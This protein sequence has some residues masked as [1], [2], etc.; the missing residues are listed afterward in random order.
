MWILLGV[1]LAAPRPPD[2]ADARLSWSLR[3]ALAADA[4]GRLDAWRYR[5]EEPVGKAGV[6]VVVHPGPE[7]DPD[8]LR[9]DLEAAGYRVE[10]A[11]GGLLQVYAPWD[12]LRALAAVP[13][14]G[15]VREPWRA[16][17]KVERVTEGYDAVMVQDWHALGVTGAGVVVGVV[18][19]GFRG[20]EALVAAGEF[21]PDA[22]VDFTRGSSESTDHG[23]AVTEVIYDFAPDASYFLVSFSTDVEFGEVLDELDGIGVDV[24]NAS[25][26]FDN[27]W[28]ADG[29]S[30]LSVFADRAVQAGAIYVGAAGNENDKYRSGA[31]AYGDGARIAIDGLYGVPCATGGGFADVSFRWSE[32]FLS[33]RQDIDLLLLNE[34]GTECGRSE[35]VQDGDGWPYEHVQAS[36]CSS[37]VTAYPYSTTGA[38]LTGLKGWLYGVYGIDPDAWTERNNLTLPGDTFDGVTVGAWYTD[39]DTLPYYSSRGPTDDGR[40][41]PE[42]VAPTAVST[43]TYGLGRFEGTSAATPHVAGVAA[44]WVSAS[45]RRDQPEKFTTWVME[46]ARDVGDPGFD[47]LTGAG[48]VQADALPEP[49]CG[50]AT[51]GAGA[52][53]SAALVGLLALGA[54]RRRR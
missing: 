32:E 23:A 9:H 5:V 41:K 16:R 13:G 19:V 15:R 42:V 17:P 6:S 7:V 26:G 33:A 53:A 2:P 45:E 14:V 29:S 31:L 50:C 20:A 54:T 52:R 44:L 36:G 38:Q 34:D 46:G 51:S 21:P 37:V 18:D 43:A 24:I 48:L 22:Q 28:H 30:S 27:V 11:S 40:D 39:T 8:G 47:G 1:A 35:D 4:E 49:G 25:I 12:E 10:A 3:E